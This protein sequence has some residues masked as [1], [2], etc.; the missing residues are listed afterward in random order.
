MVQVLLL[1]HGPLA[2]A[3][4]ESCAMLFGRKENFR[5]LCLNEDDTVDT[6]KEKILLEVEKSLDKKEVIL[7]NDIPG[8]TPSNMSLIIQKIYPEIHILAGMN[9][10]LVLECMIK[11]DFENAESIVK[12][13]VETG[14]EAIQELVFKNEETNDLDELM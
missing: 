10:P 2:S 3:M 11:S 13:I 9:L 14:K 12:S 7:L 6:F 8:G 5:A 4:L 1:S